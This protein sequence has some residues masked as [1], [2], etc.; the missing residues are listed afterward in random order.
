MSTYHQAYHSQSLQTLWI[1]RFIFQWFRWIY[2]YN[3]WQNRVKVDD[4]VLIR[5]IDGFGCDFRVSCQAV[6]NSKVFD[7]DFAKMREKIYMFKEN[8]FIINA[9]DQGILATSNRVPFR[10]TLMTCSPHAD[11]WGNSH[12]MA[13]DEIRQNSKTARERV[14]WFIEGIFTR[15][16]TIF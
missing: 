11:H 14:D 7:G 1:L 2:A 13:F 9:K 8:I 16:N 6:W 12:H 3:S 15:S 10:I 4:R 5:I